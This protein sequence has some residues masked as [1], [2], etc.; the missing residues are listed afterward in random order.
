MEEESAVKEFEDFTAESTAT[1]ETVTET[2][3]ETEQPT[4]KSVAKEPEA[5]VSSGLLL[6]VLYLRTG[7]GKSCCKSMK[8]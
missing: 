3:A 2:T 7:H 8:L 5:A 6:L 1:E 4:V